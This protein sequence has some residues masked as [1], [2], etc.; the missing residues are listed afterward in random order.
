L[1][2]R[3]LTS[4]SSSAL[5]V[6]SYCRSTCLFRST[7]FPR[8]GGPCDAPDLIDSARGLP[9][10]APFD[11]SDGRAIDPGRRAARSFPRR[12]LRPGQAGVDALDRGF[13]S[14]QVHLGNEVDFV[15]RSDRINS[16]RK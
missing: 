4:F 10:A 11:H 6:R 3:C 14:I 8:V 5:P 12:L 16:R 1:Y 13:R 2:R 9:A 7:K 15:I